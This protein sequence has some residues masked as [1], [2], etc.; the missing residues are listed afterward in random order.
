M[1]RECVSDFSSSL[2]EF[3]IKAVEYLRAVKTQSQNA[4]KNK[5]VQEAISA[6]SNLR[7]TSILTG[8]DHFRQILQLDSLNGPCDRERA[9]VL[10]ELKLNTVDKMSKETLEWL[11]QIKNAIADDKVKFIDSRRT[12]ADRADFYKSI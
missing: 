8:I 7:Y 6:I 2:R 1:E 10:D 11:T 4:I 3:L 9:E 5:V 12:E